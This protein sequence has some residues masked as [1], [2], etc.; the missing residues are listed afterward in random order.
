[1]GDG[2]YALKLNNTPAPSEIDVQYEINNLA[3]RTP[4][5]MMIFESIK[6][7]SNVEDNRINF[8]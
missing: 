3:Y 2:V 4:Y 8:Y 7:Q 6:N 1:M 5:Q